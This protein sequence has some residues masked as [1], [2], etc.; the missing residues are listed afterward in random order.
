MGTLGYTDYLTIVVAPTVINVIV[1][2]PTD[3]SSEQCLDSKYRKD[4]RDTL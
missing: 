4:G 2:G 1:A 3:S